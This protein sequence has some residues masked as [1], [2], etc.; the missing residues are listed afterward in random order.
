MQIAVVSYK[1]KKRTGFYI[2]SIADIFWKI[3]KK[4]NDFR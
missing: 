4:L 2:K 3:K 1:L